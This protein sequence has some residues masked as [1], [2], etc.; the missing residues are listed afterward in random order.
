M[1]G[2]NPANYRQ[3]TPTQSLALLARVVVGEGGLYLGIVA[4]PL[5]FS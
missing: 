4:F 2:K 5:L 1:A 3:R